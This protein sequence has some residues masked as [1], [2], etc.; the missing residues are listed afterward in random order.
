MEVQILSSAA[1]Q[2]REFHP[3]EATLLRPVFSG[4][5]RA[6]GAGG[7]RRIFDFGCFI[8]DLEKVLTSCI[9]GRRSRAKV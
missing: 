2:A 4:L 7:G 6:H 8:F 5:R 1:K 3:P 9:P